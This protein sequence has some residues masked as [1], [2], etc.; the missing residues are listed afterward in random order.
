[1]TNEGGLKSIVPRL[2]KSMCLI[3]TTMLKVSVIA[4]YS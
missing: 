4:Y 2:S 1:M 3:L